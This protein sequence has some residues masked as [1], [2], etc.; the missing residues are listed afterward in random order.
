MTAQEIMTGLSTFK[1]DAKYNSYIAINLE[2]GCLMERREWLR[3]NDALFVPGKEYHTDE[4]WDSCIGNTITVY[5]HNG[6][7]IIKVF[8]GEGCVW[9]ALRRV[10]YNMEEVR[11]A[12]PQF[13]DDYPTECKEHFYICI[14]ESD[15]AYTDLEGNPVNDIVYALI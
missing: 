11:T 15:D 13:T 2:S 10:G 9:E 4:E 7:A 14:R 6:T 3:R 1:E 8:D 12:F 5:R